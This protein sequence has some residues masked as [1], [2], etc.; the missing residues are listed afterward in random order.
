MRNPPHPR[1]WLKRNEMTINEILGLI[2]ELDGNGLHIT[3]IDE[4]EQR[5]VE[6]GYDYDNPGR[7][8]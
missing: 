7:G 4:I 3:D 2:E 1:G 5:L 6:L 8:N